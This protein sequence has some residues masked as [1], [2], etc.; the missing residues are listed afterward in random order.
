MKLACPACGAEVQFKS[1]ASVFGV[2]S[3]CSSTLVRHDMDIESLG[4]MSEMPQDMSPLQI[5]STGIHERSRFEVV[6]RQKISWSDGVWNEWYVLFDNGKDGWLADAQGFYMISFQL[7]TP[8][9]LPAAG[10]L[11]VGANLKLQG[12]VFNVDDIKD[13]ACS[14][15]EGELPVKSVHGRKSTSVDLVGPENQ[16][17]NIDFAAEGNRL[18]LGK[19]VEFDDLQLTNLREIDGW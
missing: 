8:E 2:C 4:K 6:G 10:A 11:Q 5:G 17:G 9:D 1:R 18:F 12:L 15:S 19:Y 14:G 16:F 3:F 13:V 7:P